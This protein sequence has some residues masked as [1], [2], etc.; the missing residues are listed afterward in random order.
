LGGDRSKPGGPEGTWGGRQ[1]VGS[2]SSTWVAQGGKKITGQ[3]NEWGSIGG[4][5][6]RGTKILGGGGKNRGVS[7]EKKKGQEIGGKDEKVTDANSTISPNNQRYT[8][9]KV[10]VNKKGQGGGGVRVGA[11]YTGACC[12]RGDQA[13]R[14]G[15]IWGCQRGVKPETPA[16]LD[17]A[18]KDWKIEREE[19]MGRAGHK[20]KNE[21]ETS[22]TGVRRKF[23]PT[24]LLGKVKK[25]NST[26]GFNR[27]RQAKNIFAEDEKTLPE[28]RKE[29]SRTRKKKRRA[30]RGE[31]TW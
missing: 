23:G 25:G 28:E 18:A 3:R 1:K 6:F 15:G 26:N 31:E 21:Q 20:K 30:K 14:E 4:N 9:K 17:R 2:N 13:L 29:G 24:Q 19:V 5:D 22:G 12:V 7:L 10:N 27:W 16:Y 11:P 8:K